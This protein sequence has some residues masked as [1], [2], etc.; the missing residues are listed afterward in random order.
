MISAASQT[1]DCACE[2]SLSGVDLPSP[3][4]LVEFVNNCRLEWA[5]A[6][7]GA[8]R[9]GIAGSSSRKDSRRVPAPRDAELAP[10]REFAH[11]LPSPLRSVANLP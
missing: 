11:R 8:D 7:G 10:R 5:S 1:A 2:F 3:G 9:S 6:A 4:R